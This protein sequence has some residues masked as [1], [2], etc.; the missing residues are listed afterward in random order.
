M[1]Y[2]NLKHKRKMI[3]ILTKHLKNKFIKINLHKNYKIY[4]Y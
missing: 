2:T 1:L 3:Y 4:Y